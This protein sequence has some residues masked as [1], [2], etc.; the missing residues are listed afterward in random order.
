VAVG[1]SVLPLAG[2]RGALSHRSGLKESP[3][4]SAA[5][6]DSMCR[7]FANVSAIRS[8]LLHVTAARC[9]CCGNNGRKM[10]TRLAADIILHALQELVGQFDSIQQS[11]P[12]SKCR[13]GARVPSA[14]YRPFASRRSSDQSDVF[15]EKSNSFCSFYCGTP[16]ARRSGVPLQLQ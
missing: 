10:G 16:P 5:T 15:V 4:S 3:V 7:I 8:A 6:I 2:G 13:A 11:L 9:A 12:F 14:I 1:Q